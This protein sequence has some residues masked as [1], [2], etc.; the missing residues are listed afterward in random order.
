MTLFIHSFV[1]VI[2][3]IIPTEERVIYLSRMDAVITV[4]CVIGQAAGGVLGMNNCRVP[5][6]VSAGLSAIAML[7]AIVG[8]KESN[9][10][11]LAKRQH[12]KQTSESSTES[13]PSSETEVEMKTQTGA[14]VSKAPVADVEAN[15]PVS[16]FHI[17]TL[18]II[19]FIYT[20]CFSFSTAGYQSRYCLYI[21]EKFSMSTF[22]LSYD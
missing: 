15:K 4:A 19:C 17:T 12:S 13:K 14:E 2:A 16:T 11:I 20:L 21:T 1:S 10:K 18:S 3:D 6:Y 9:P 22:T 7:V 8:A 5:L